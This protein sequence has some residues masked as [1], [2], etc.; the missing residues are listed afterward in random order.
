MPHFA[1]RRHCDLPN[2][3]IRPGVQCACACVIGRL[4]VI[5]SV[6]VAPRRGRRRWRINQLEKEPGAAA[7]PRY[8][9]YSSDVEY[10]GK[11]SEIKPRPAGP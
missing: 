11:L 10:S 5:R 4:L 1:R 8:L 7:K 2:S 3:Q 6:P 9:N